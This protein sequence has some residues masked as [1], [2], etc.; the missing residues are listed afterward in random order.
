MAASTIRKRVMAL[1]ANKTF[2]TFFPGDP[3]FLQQPPPPR[4]KVRILGKK[5]FF[6]PFCVSLDPP[7][8]CAPQQASL[9]LPSFARFFTCFIAGHWQ[10]PLDGCTILV[11][12]PPPI[13]SV[14]TLPFLYDALLVHLTAAL[15]KLFLF[16]SPSDNYSAQLLRLHDRISRLVKKVLLRSTH[17]EFPY[18]DSVLG[19][20]SR[21]ALSPLRYLLVSILHGA[22]LFA[23]LYRFALLQSLSLFRPSPPCLRS[24]SLSA[25]GPDACFV[26]LTRMLRF[27]PEET[28]FLQPR[29]PS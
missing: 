28:W 5:A 26:E 10:T 14:F 25:A 20:G 1:L 27:G 7:S 17:L 24:L 11:R 9:G 13:D 29:W 21:V 19:K 15:D 8:L 16:V 18:S 22:F 23:S 4:R 12:S 3:T 2:G 6:S